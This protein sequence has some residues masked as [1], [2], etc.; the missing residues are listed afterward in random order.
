MLSI[1]RTAGISELPVVSNEQLSEEAADFR[2]TQGGLERRLAVFS[3][4]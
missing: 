2:L 3:Y 4:I 1:R